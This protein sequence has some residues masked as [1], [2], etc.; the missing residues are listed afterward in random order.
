MLYLPQPP[1]FLLLFGL[2]VSLTCGLSFEALLK[3]KVNE[4]SKQR[5]TRALAELQG[6]QLLLP[7]LGICAGI[8]IFLA[9]GLEIFTFNRAFSYLVAAPLTLFIGDLVWSQLGKVLSQIETGG[10]QA[11]DWDL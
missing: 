8:C 1:Y 2:L 3:Q 6:M 7:F 10:S 5:S 4:W 9:A 11:L